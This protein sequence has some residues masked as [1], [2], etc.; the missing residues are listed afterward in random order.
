MLQLGV[1]YKYS[2]WNLKQK[3]CCVTA[4]NGIKKRN[5]VIKIKI[6]VTGVERDKGS[7]IDKS[8]GKAVE[9]DN[10]QLYYDILAGL[11]KPDNE[12][13]VFAV[14]TP[15]G[16][17]KIKLTD[18]NVNHIFHK[19]LTDDDFIG[20]QDNEYYIFF[21]EKKKLDSV[22]PAALYEQ[23]IGVNSDENVVVF[24]NNGE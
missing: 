16:N 6:K 23:L 15:N 24:R 5:G 14:G 17:T 2:N 11:E 10:L 8:T 12:R 4:L 1:L 9:Y 3:K 21:D 20:M 19:P 7:F 13:Q 22:F 18:E